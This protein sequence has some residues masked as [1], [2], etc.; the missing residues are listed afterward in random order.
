MRHGRWLYLVP[1][2]FGI[3][4]SP[5]FA[6]TDCLIEGPANVELNQTFTMCGPTGSGYEY[7]WYG[8]GLTQGTQTRCVTA[9]LM[10]SSTFEYVLVVGQNGTELARCKQVVNSGSVTGGARSCA[11]TGPSSIRVGETARLCGPS[12]GL[13]TYTWTGPNYFQET[14]ACVTVDDDGTYYLTSRNSLTGSTRQ[15]T[16]QLNVV[17]TAE[18]DCLSGPTVIDAGTTAQLCAPTRSN[19]TY[20]WTGPSG[21]V[22]STR[23]V[24]VDDPGTYRVAMRNNTSGRT[25][26]CGQTLALTNVDPEPGENPDEIVW[27]NCPRPL[28]F[29]RDAFRT[30]GNG[31]LSQA[32][33][34]AIARSVD[35]RSTYFNWSN[36]LAGM[37]AALSPAS[38]LTRRKQVARQY[39]TTLANVVAGE[40]SLTPAGRSQIGLDLDTQVDYPGTSNLR[41]LMTVTDRT[42]RATRGNLSRLNSTLTAVNQGR[43]IGPTCE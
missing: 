18:V 16:H 13:H 14:G 2:L 26:R 9:R 12:D 41:S 37:R 17:G 25:D 35:E 27:D 28:Q 5:S 21:F 11:I 31:D 24:T 22:A 7:D 30:N 32:D 19:T 36:D 42:L 39:A 40:L 43:D 20:R 15:C 3:L 34:Q 38:P 8:P 23:C 29:W 4:T 10:T 6:Q 33:L 1:V